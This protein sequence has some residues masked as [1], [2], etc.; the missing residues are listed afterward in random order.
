ME[1]TEINGM[2]PAISQEGI[3]AL[4]QKLEKLVSGD[5]LVLAGSIPS[6]MPETIYRD[7]MERLD[8]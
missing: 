2:G 1:G 5:Y 6:T 7:I 4:Y 8:G 3:N